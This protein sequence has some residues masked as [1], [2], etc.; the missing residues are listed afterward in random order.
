[1][2]TKALLSGFILQIKEAVKLRRV[3]HCDKARRAFESTREF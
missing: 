3:L 1:M 2:S